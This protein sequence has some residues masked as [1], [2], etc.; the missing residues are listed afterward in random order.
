MYRFDNFFFYRRI[1][2]QQSYAV[3]ALVKDIFD[4]IF[5]IY[6]NSDKG[7]IKEETE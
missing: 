5:V 2:Y 6:A 7:E 4:I 3:S 1:S